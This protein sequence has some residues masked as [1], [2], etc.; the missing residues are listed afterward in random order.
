MGVVRFAEVKA[1]EVTVRVVA[2]PLV[3]LVVSVAGLKVQV[4]PEGR[5]E[6]ASV[7][8]EVRATEGLTTT[9]MELLLP[10]ETVSVA[11]VVTVKVGVPVVRV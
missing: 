3:V 11:E 5:P 4:L 9:L 10:L 1:A 6:Q 7:T 2:E 8:G